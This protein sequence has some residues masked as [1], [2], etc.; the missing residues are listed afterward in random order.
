M[1]SNRLQK[2]SRGYLV[3]GRKT[4]DSEASLLSHR[5]QVRG[6]AII[7]LAIVNEANYSVLTYRKTRTV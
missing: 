1:R 5:K 3:T 6:A 7:L 4:D 2:L